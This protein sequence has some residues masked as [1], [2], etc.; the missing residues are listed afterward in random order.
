MKIER[1]FHIRPS[2][3]TRATPFGEKGIPT[4]R[5]GATV[6]VVGEDS[7]WVQVQVAFCSAKDAFCRDFGRV[8]AESHP[9]KLIKL[10]ELPG[11]LG[12]ISREVTKRVLKLSHKKRQESPLWSTDYSFAKK[13]FLPKESN[14]L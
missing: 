13:Y 1:F 9:I 5:G 6:R 12:S 7:Q 10:E 3:G 8:Y 4:T 14:V 11:E 2:S